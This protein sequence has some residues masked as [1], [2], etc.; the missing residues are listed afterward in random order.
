M[1]KDSVLNVVTAIGFKTPVRELSI[2]ATGFKNLTYASNAN[3][4]NTAQ[5]S[6]LEISD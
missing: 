1:F 2:T 3:V 5:I 6:N 4:I